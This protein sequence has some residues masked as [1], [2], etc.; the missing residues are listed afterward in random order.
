M[1]GMSCRNFRR[2]M[3]PWFNIL[4][5]A[6]LVLTVL[7]VRR[8]LILLVTHHVD[9]VIE[10]FDRVIDER[11]GLIRRNFRRLRRWFWQRFGV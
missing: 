4:I 11:V 8:M 10:E 3:R 9:P 1:P 7:I 6:L 5:I 2:R